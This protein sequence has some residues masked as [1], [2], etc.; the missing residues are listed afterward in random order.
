MIEASRTKAG[1]IVILVSVE[2]ILEINRSIARVTPSIGEDRSPY[3]IVIL[4]YVE[5]I[6]ESIVD[7]IFNDNLVSN[8]INVDLCYLR[9]KQPKLILL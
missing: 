3:N 4:V 9:V 2:A 1:N 6:H 8:Y 7:L 5:T